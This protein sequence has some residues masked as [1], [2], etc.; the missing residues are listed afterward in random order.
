MK[1]F[2]QASVILVYETW[3]NAKKCRSKR[4]LSQKNT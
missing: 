4:N 2:V 3:F 1:N